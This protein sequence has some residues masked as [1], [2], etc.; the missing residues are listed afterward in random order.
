MIACGDDLLQ[1]LAVGVEALQLVLACGSCDVDDALL[2]LSG[3]LIVFGILKPPFLQRLLQK[4]YLLPEDIAPDAASQEPATE[5]PAP[6][7]TTA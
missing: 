1:P 7:P 5:D 2:N 4:L 3:T 6:P